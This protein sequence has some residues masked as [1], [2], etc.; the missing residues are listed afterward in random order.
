MP[1]YDLHVSVKKEDI[2]VR[3]FKKKEKAQVTF[4]VSACYGW[5]IMES[6]CSDQL[7]IQVLFSGL[8]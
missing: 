3:P 7:Q 2:H 8:K 4:A 5:W 1:V 6:S